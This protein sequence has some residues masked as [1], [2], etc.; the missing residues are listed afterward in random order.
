MKRAGELRSSPARLNQSFIT[1]GRPHSRLPANSINSAARRSSL[2]WT[3]IRNA[4]W[5]FAQYDHALPKPARRLEPHA[6]GPW[7]ESL[8]RAWY[9]VYVVYGA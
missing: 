8:L 6:F 1:K 3:F 7:V 2:G 4:T 9:A 5:S